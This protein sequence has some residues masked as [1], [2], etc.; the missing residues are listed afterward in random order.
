MRWACADCDQWPG[1]L[2]WRH[3]PAVKL[4]EHPLV[5]QPAAQYDATRGHPHRQLGEGVR[6]VKPSVVGKQ[7]AASPQTVR[8]P[9]PRRGF[10]MWRPRR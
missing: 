8:T 6:T 3:N 9:W 1:Y 7:P 2:C 4:L 10:T 5:E